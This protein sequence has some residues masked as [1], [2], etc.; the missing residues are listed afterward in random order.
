LLYMSIFPENFE[1]RRDRLVWRWRA[2]EFVHP[3]TEPGECLFDLG[4]SYFYTI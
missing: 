4:Q 2:E 1:I 3:S